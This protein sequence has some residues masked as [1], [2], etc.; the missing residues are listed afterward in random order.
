MTIFSFSC[1]EPF[2]VLKIISKWFNTIIY[3]LKSNSL[4][5]RLTK[6]QNVQEKQQ[7]QQI[8]RQ[9]QHP[10]LIHNNCKHVPPI[11][12]TRP[13]HPIQI[14]RK[15]HHNKPQQQQQIHTQKTQL[16]NSQENQATFRLCQTNPATNQDPMYCH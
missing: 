13:H 3:G 16:I 1:I 2:K 11:L 4:L 8:L 5:S 7:I 14:P 9:P 6:H 12:T 10:S 15:L